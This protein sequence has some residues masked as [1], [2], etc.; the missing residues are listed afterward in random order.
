MRNMVIALGMVIFTSST[1]LQTPMVA[2]SQQEV[3][4]YAKWSRLAIQETQL[5]YPNAKIIDY[6]YKGR[7]S[8]ENSTIDTFKLWL[9]DDHNNE[10]GVFVRVEYNTKTENLVNIELQETPR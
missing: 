1:S 10:F 4:S 6:L 7:E 5:K 3:P 9:R 8:K 2:Y